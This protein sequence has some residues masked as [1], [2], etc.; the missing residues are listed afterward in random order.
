ME[1]KGKKIESK[2][3]AVAPLLFFV[4]HLQINLNKKKSFYLDKYFFLRCKIRK[5][6][7]INEVYTFLRLIEYISL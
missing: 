4:T 1:C 2:L 6:R 5:S 7:L 3:K